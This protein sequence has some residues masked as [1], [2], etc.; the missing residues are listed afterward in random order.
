MNKIFR[1]LLFIVCMII[2]A[3]SAMIIAHADIPAGVKNGYKY[4]Q[5]DSSIVIVKNRLKDLGYFG[6]GSSTFSSFVS[7][8]LKKAVISFQRQNKVV[9]DGVLD[10]DLL[11]L[12][13]SDDAIGKD[14]KKVRSAS[15][16][17]G[18]ASPAGTKAPAVEREAS[19]VVAKKG[20]KESTPDKTKDVNLLSIV[21]PL[22]IVGIII[23]VLVSI[24]KS[25]TNYRLNR[26]IAI[27]ERYKE[28]GMDA[29]CKKA[30]NESGI[31]LNLLASGGEYLFIP[32]MFRNN[33]Y[34]LRFDSNIVQE[35][36]KR[37]G[38]TIVAKLDT[39]ARKGLVESVNHRLLDI[40]GARKDGKK[41]NINITVDYDK[42]MY[43]YSSLVSS[44]IIR[45]ADELSKDAF[46]LLA[47]ECALDDNIYQKNLVEKYVRE[48]TQLARDD[49]GDHTGY[50]AFANGKKVSGIAD[51]YQNAVYV[52]YELLDV[53]EATITFMMTAKDYIDNGKK[54]WHDLYSQ[55]SEEVKSVLAE[56]EKRRYVDNL[57][58]GD[59]RPRISIDA[60]NTMQPAAFEQLVAALF[61]KMGYDAKT[62]KLSGD[63]GV[64][65][66]AEKKGR[67]VVIQAKCYQGSVGNSAVQ[68]VV[69]GKQ[70]YHANEAFVVT[71][72]VFTKS[73]IELARANNVELWDR[74][75]L[76]QMLDRYYVYY[77]DLVVS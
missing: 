75:V 60:T 43:L 63:Q 18:Q 40:W 34:M 14:G 74:S 9:A 47:W 30:I 48:A 54:M 24:S 64:D 25:I 69:A 52:L 65:V 50:K 28:L 42:L 27:L 15:V 13:F 41:N 53:K 39:I 37:C 59:R 51:N 5:T 46:F 66:V 3:F 7:E 21:L 32:L 16:A 61:N 8:D 36:E 57:L 6:S 23:G 19:T 56:I 17:D 38:T 2:I 31:I 35:A 45:Q 49:T 70:F 1:R 44:G 58:K 68:E 76:A 20:T 33:H 26:L 11:E 67:R 4:N 71:N 55:N 62:T 77:S 29:R 73:A 10:K 12:L 72:S 22:L